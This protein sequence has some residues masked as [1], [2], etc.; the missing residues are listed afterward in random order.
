MAINPFFPPTGISS[1]HASKARSDR[2]SDSSGPRL[3]VA[4]LDSII[5]RLLQHALA[6]STLR[7]YDVA[8]RRYLTKI[9][10]SPLPVS[11]PYCAGM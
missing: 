5:Q 10:T 7:S 2:E 9:N 6:P 4:K 1:T 11:E 3:D 8:Q